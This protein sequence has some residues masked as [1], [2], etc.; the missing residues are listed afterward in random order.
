M[1]FT[2]LAVVI[3]GLC[4]TPSTIMCHALVARVDQ[5]FLNA[6]YL[7]NLCYLKASGDVYL[8]GKRW[9]EWNMKPQPT[10]TP[11]SSA[12]AALLCILHSLKYFFHKSFYCL[13]RPV[14]KQLT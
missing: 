7:K 4:K 14:G 1:F 5:W 2:I 3:S 8:M 9:C 12:T 10:P 13:K 11:A 6:C